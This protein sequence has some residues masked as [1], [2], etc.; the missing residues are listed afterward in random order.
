[1]DSAIYQSLVIDQ[2][3]PVRIAIGYNGYKS[4]YNSRWSFYN[5]Y[6][7]MRKFRTFK[8]PSLLISDGF[9]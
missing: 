1:M 4:E 5:H 2:L 8:I 7:D 9:S 6:S 3:T